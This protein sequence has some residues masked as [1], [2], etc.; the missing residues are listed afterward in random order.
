MLLV[1]YR[2]LI[3]GIN[4]HLNFLTMIT[5]IMTL[6]ILLTDREFLVNHSTFN[7][8]DISL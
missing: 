7:S 1:D 3:D 2:L 8:V 5:L 4:N 6:F